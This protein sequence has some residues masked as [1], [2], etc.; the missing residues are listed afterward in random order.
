MNLRQ[1]FRLKNEQ[2]SNRIKVIKPN[3][4]S[5]T[6]IKKMAGSIPSA[7]GMTNKTD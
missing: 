5:R 2:N 4:S 7:S 6:G 1:P 3:T